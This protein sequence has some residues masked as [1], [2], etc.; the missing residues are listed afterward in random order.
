MS[1]NEEAKDSRRK[2]RHQPAPRLFH[3]SGMTEDDRRQ[4]RR[5]QRKLH[6]DVDQ[7][8]DRGDDEERMDYLAR[9]RS[10]NNN[11]FNKVKFTREATLDAE[12]NVLIAKK[13]LQEV[14]QMVQGTYLMHNG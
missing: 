5:N 3:D 14:D 12:N 10:T 8:I 1:D 7:E 4:L 2:R 9:K 11:L 6:H 13:T